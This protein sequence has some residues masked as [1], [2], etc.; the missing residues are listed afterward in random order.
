LLL[1]IFNERRIEQIN[2]EYSW[3]EFEIMMSNQCGRGM[4]FGTRETQPSVYASEIG[5]EIEPSL[6]ITEFPIGDVK[7]TLTEIHS[8][9]H[10]VRAINHILQIDDLAD[11]CPGSDSKLPLRHVRVNPLLFQTPVST[12]IKQSKI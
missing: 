5:E 3:C 10:P 7:E 12:A 1:L 2:S 4:G 11:N 8:V 6:Q 9:L